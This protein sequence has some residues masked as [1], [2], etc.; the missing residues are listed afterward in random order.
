MSNGRWNVQHL[1]SM[2]PENIVEKVCSIQAGRRHSGCDRVIWG[3]SKCGNFSVKTAFLGLIE[4]DSL[5]LWKWSFQWKTRMPPRIRYFLWILLQ[6]KILTNHHRAAR[7]L[8]SDPS[9]P[10]CAAG[11]EDLS[12]LVRSCS[13]TTEI[14][15]KTLCS[16][17]QSASFQ[18]SLDDWFFENL[19]NNNVVSVVEEFDEKFEKPKTK[20][21][22][23]AMRRWG[24]DP[25]QKATFL[26]MDVSE[27]VEKSSRNIGTLKMLT[28][29]TLNLFDILDAE[30][31]VLTPSSVDFL[32]GRYGVELEGEED[33]EEEVEEEEG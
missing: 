3:W 11:I 17:T 9:C 13:H 4:A 33:E 30:T 31:L 2:L 19:R 14:W 21:F 20:E 25:K 26:M 24:L 27:N 6:G 32:N 28:P 7:G 1:A 5:P 18:G 15:K 8:T 12:H 16:C 23:E 10:R 22:I 29:R